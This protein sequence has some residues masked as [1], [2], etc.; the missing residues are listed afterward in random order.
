MSPAERQIQSRA[1]TEV[2]DS[3]QTGST[4]AKQAI[5]VGRF[6]IA[7]R[8][9][10]WIGHYF[11]ALSK[12]P[13]CA[14]PFVGLQQIVAIHR[15]SDINFEAHR[16]D[17][18]LPN[19]PVRDVDIVFVER[20]AAQGVVVDLSFDDSYA[21]WCCTIAMFHRPNG[22]LVRPKNS[23]R[24]HALRKARGAA[25]RAAACQWALSR[26]FRTAM[27]PSKPIAVA[28]TLSWLA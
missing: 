10:E 4:A 13:Q 9:S 6:A 5:D 12:F 16:V 18:R 17:G 2:V 15:Q 19:V 20:T 11:L 22:A 26:T 23:A 1:V 8:F 25:Q 21:S 3:D 27:R 24:R 14:S 28:R 7:G